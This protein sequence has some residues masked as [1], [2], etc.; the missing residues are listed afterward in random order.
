MITLNMNKYLLA[1]SVCCVANAALTSCADEFDQSYSVERPALTGEYAYLNDYKPLKEYVANPNF[2]LGVGTTVADYLKQ[3]LVYS[4]TNSNFNE[5][6]A[7]N[8]MKM[9][10]CVSDNGTMDFSTV[11]QYVNMATEAGLS[12][13]GHTLA[14]HSQQPAKWLNSLLK[15]RELDIDPDAKIETLVS[16]K[17]YQDGP[18]PFYPMGC[19]PPVING[20][21]HFVPTGDWSQFF[22]F[23][24]ITATPSANYDYQNAEAFNRRPALSSMPRSALPLCLSEN[25]RFMF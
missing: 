3:E 1:C 13:Y 17:T 18:F 11:S 2:K 24:G 15:D 16:S 10:S 14:W 19:E 25:I 20:A 8:A 7:G 23:P 5:T 22:I 9:A 21:L 6:V 4:L 12:V